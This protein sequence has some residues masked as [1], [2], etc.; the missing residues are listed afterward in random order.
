[1]RKRTRHVVPYTLLAL[2]LTGC[3][4]GDSDLARLHRAQKDF[5]QAKHYQQRLDIYPNQTLAEESLEHYREIAR[6]FP[7][8]DLPRAIEDPDGIPVKLARVGAMSS[9]GAAG[10]LRELGRP[11][12]AIATLESACRPDLP[13]GALVERMLRNELASHLL[14]AERPVDAIAAYHSLLAPLAPDLHEEHAA[15]PNEEVLALPALMVDLAKETGDSLLTADTDRLVALYFDG[16][17]RHY[18]DSDVEWEALLRSADVAITLEHWERA[19]QNLRKLA[20][21]FP[22]RE[23]WRAELRRATLLSEQLGRS[24]ESEAILL[25]WATDGVGDAAVEASLQWIRLLLRTERREQ[26]LE[27]IRRIKKMTNRRSDQAELLYLWGVLELGRGSWEE[28]RPRWGQAAASHPYTRYGMESQLAIAHNWSE[29]EEPR[30]AARSLA[31][32]FR[33]CRRNTRHRAGSEL[34]RLSLEIES[35]ADSLLGTLPA[36][37]PMVRTLV[38]KRN[39]NAGGVP[40]RSP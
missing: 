21:R 30:F 37:E 19:T 34:S 25:R 22:D 40:E 18:P 1:M 39:P 8:A 20:E 6:R 32:L 23:P 38:E 16:V 24:E 5:W 12:E 17:S 13:L 27:Q 2:L 26:A 4:G 36:S 28:A 14:E 11:D 35:R 31:R 9:L 29:R 3:V 7:L 10:I 15:Y 33:A